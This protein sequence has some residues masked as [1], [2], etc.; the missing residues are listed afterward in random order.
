MTDHQCAT[1]V[2]MAATENNYTKCNMLP[3][4]GYV[5][6]VTSPLSSFSHGSIF[7]ARRRHAVAAPRSVHPEREKMP[8]IVL[9]R[10]QGKGLFKTSTLG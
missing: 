2:K 1:K 8:N 6:R 9:S 7:G 4:V 5:P 3:A 10:R